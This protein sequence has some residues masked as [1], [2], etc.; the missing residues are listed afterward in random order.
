MIRAASAFQ[1]CAIAC[2]MASAVI[3]AEA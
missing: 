1:T 3:A 2:C